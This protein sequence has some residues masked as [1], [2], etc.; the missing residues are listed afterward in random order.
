MTAIDTEPF[1]DDMDLFALVDRAVRDYA[2]FFDRVIL[3]DM[4]Q[5]YGVTRR[6]L[7]VLQA[8]KSE[9]GAADRA[10]LAQLVGLDQGALQRALINLIGRE[11]VVTETRNENTLK[12]VI[13][14]TETGEMALQFAETRMKSVL[15]DPDIRMAITLSETERMELTT[16]LIKLDGRASIL[17]RAMDRFEAEQ[18]QSVTELDGSA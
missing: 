16:A 18:S 12:T 13:G 5:H 7:R 8:M 14:L 15:S 4:L 10:T 1:Y 3:S 6:G 11:L 2:R 9:G 17:N